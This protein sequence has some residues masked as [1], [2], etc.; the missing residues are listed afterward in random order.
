[1]RGNLGFLSYIAGRPWLRRAV[2][3][4]PISPTKHGERTHSTNPNL[5]EREQ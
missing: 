1:M 2:R 3:Q 4:T 5:Q